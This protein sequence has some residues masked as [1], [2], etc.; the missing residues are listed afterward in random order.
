MTLPMMS[1]YASD[2]LV[3]WRNKLNLVGQW[4][5]KDDEIR[6]YLERLIESSGDKEQET[7]PFLSNLY[8]VKSAPSPAPTIKKDLTVGVEEAMDTARKAIESLPT[9][10]LCVTLRDMGLDALAIIQA[11]LR[12]K[13]VTKVRL[14]VMATEILRLAPPMDSMDRQVL[15]IEQVRNYLAV[16]L[17]ELGIEVGEKP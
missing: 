1:V 15:F 11:A 9:N 2:K 6:T 12:P 13:V 8:G 10:S 5:K 4:S 3:D 7:D 14:A 16:H 17:R